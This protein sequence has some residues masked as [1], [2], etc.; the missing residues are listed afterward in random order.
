MKP[1]LMLVEMMLQ[2]CGA[3]YNYQ[4]K[5]MIQQTRHVKAMVTANK[6]QTASINA[7]SIYNSFK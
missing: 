2:E 5:K 1:S 4:K 3:V 7:Y 6:K